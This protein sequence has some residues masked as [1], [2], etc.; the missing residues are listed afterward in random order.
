MLIHSISRIIPSVREQTQQNG[1]NDWYARFHVEDEHESNKCLHNKNEKNKR[2]EI[3][4][5]VD[6]HNWIWFLISI[7]HIFEPLTLWHTQTSMSS[8][9]KWKREKIWT[10]FESDWKWMKRTREREREKKNTK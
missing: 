7:N 6:R 3:D 9:K 8:H 1:I 5:P 2:P 4:P 10:A